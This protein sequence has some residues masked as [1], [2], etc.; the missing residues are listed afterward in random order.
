ML[1]EIKRSEWPPFFR[2]FNQRNQMR[3]TRLE[4]VGGD[5][6]TKADSGLSVES[7]YWMEDGLPLAGVSLEPGSEGAARVEIMLGGEAARPSDHMTHTVTGAQRV[8][9]TLSADG[10]ECELEIEDEEGAVTILH[11]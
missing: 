9:R 3:P 7:D 5:A 2:E 8:I 1:E 4:V 6:P 11:F 10:H